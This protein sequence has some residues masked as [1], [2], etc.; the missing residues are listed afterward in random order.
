METNLSITLNLACKNSPPKLLRQNST[1]IFDENY[2]WVEYKRV[3]GELMELASKVNDRTWAELINHIDD[4]RYCTTIITQNGATLNLT[5]GHVCGNVVAA[6]LRAGYNF[7]VPTQS[8]EDYLLLERIAGFQGFDE[9]K[10]LLDK[11]AAKSILQLQLTIGQDALRNLDDTDLPTSRKQ[12]WGNQIKENLKQLE[13]TQ[14]FERPSWFVG[15][16]FGIYTK[17][18]ADGLRTSNTKE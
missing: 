10:A 13:R 1:P 2:D 11:N 8:I 9:M 15:E 14:H 7:R 4:D 16:Q 12:E 6:T 3:I 5:V 18:I 17:S